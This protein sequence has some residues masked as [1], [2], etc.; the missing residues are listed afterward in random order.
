M[1]LVF[2]LVVLCL[3][4]PTDVLVHG[5]SDSQQLSEEPS[6]A[7]PR[8]AEG[9]RS[10]HTPG[11]P[12][13]DG[14]R[15]PLPPPMCLQTTG[16]RDTF[17]SVNTLV[18]LLVFV[19][20]TVGNVALLRIIHAD[21]GMR[22][23]PNVLIA[24]LAA[25]DLIHIV[26]DIPI[27]AY[28]VSRRA[29]RTGAGITTESGMNRPALLSSP[30]LFPCCLASIPEPLNVT[31]LL[32]CINCSVLEYGLSLLCFCAVIMRLPGLPP[33]HSYPS[34]EGRIRLL[35]SSSTLLDLGGDFPAPSQ[36]SGLECWV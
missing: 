18:S 35:C 6:A 30:L 2:V 7:G 9:P 5:T 32:T 23:R 28:R 21:C 8:L 34:A 27:N 29:R 16:I 13:L 25:G 19:T 24:S 3:Q 26:I 10:N 15:P 31:C 4:R 20:G 33:L 12:P 22:S 17:K 14:P 36:G 1:W 11:T